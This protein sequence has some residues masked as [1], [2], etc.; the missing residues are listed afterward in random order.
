MAYAKNKGLEN[1]S[2]FCAYLLAHLKRLGIKV[3]DVGIQTDNDGAFVGNWRPGSPSTFTYVIEEIYKALHMRIPP[4]APTYNS[5][6]ETDD[7][8]HIY[9]NTINLCKSSTE[10]HHVPGLP[11]FENYLETIW[12]L[13][14][15][16]RA[17]NMSR[18]FDRDPAG[19]IC[20]LLR[21]GKS[22]LFK[23]GNHPYN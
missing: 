10:G 20:K 19:I 15:G 3:E 8:F 1:A 16:R 7:N 4:A 6:V 2:T 13:P 9:L 14:T 12:N 21:A 17:K 22:D 18:R 5:D 11:I 23:A